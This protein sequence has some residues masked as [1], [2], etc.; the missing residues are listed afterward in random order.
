MQRK[1]SKY[2]VK[3]IEAKANYNF[4]NGI[5]H[6]G[7]L[8]GLSAALLDDELI[9]SCGF[10]K[11]YLNHENSI[12]KV[13]HLHP[14]FSDIF[15]TP[16]KEVKKVIIKINVWDNYVLFVGTKKVYD[17]KYKHSIF[18]RIET[19]YPNAVIIDKTI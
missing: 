12:M 3:L 6:D 10:K 15:N 1:L 18:D 17:A 14:E 19:H 11:E 13:S 16:T 8:L 4:S 9:L 5:L 7:Y 2:T